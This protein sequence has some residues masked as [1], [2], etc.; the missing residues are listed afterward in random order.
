MIID[1]GVP[2]PLARKLCDE[3]LDVVAFPNDWKQLSNGALLV[4]IVREGFSVLITNDKNMQHQ[5][6]LGQRP[7]AVV[8]LPTNKL[9]DLKNMSGKI[10]AAVRAAT[11]GRFLAV[12][13]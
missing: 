8:I 9:P 2:R 4:Q 11:A 3:G 6:S 12:E 1:E 13:A 10:A 7:L 5:Q